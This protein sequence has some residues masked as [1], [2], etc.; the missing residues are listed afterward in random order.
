MG[1]KS[2][3]HL[4]RLFFLGLVFV[5][6]GCGQRRF[7]PAEIQKQAEGGDADA[8]WKLGR[9]FFDDRDETNALL[10]MCK[11][12]EK[13]NPMGEYYLGTMYWNGQGSETNT[14]RG[15]YYIS[16]AANQHLP[17]AEGWMGLYYLNGL[18]ARRDDGQAELWLKKA[19]QHGD[20]SAQYFLGD[21]YT[22]NHLGVCWNNYREAEKWM[23]KAAVQGNRKAQKWMASYLVS[24]TV[25]KPDLVEAYMWASILGSKGLMQSIGIKMTATQIKK[26][27]AKAERFQWK[28]HGG[29]QSFQNSNFL[30]WTLA[31]VIALEWGWVTWWFFKRR[32]SHRKVT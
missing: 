22:H 16:T 4:N 15:F 1:A 23:K 20:S 14:D 17:A 24:P 8:Q 31:I 27:A 28:G 7:S 3:Y 21:F 29:Y 30:L 18:G 25:G 13:R 19:A 2:L 26:A 11:S 10:W 6:V 32:L 9:L 12:A 5:L